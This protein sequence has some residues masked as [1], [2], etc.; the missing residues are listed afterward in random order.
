M[1]LTRQE[2][3]DACAAMAEGVASACREALREAGIGAGDVADVE[4]LGGG[5]YVPMLRSAVE[6]VFG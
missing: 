1:T 4:L 3:E 6:G 5:S 2:A